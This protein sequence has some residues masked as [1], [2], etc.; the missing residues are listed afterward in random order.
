M[1]V[2]AANKELSES[3]AES[4]ALR[5]RVERCE[6]REREVLVGPRLVG[7]LVGGAVAVAALLLVVGCMLLR[8]GRAG[9]KPEARME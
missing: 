5:E 2:A 4:N 7:P 1:Q 3:E 9:R 6:A 8:P